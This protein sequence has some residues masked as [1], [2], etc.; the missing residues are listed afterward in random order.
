M[1]VKNTMVFCEG[2]SDVVA[3]VG[4][5]GSAS[6]VYGDTFGNIFNPW[7]QSKCFLEVWDGGKIIDLPILYKVM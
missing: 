4:A 3:T 7:S 2:F 1:K 6:I 5:K